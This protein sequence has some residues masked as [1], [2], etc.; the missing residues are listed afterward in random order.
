MKRD[1]GI[2]T[3]TYTLPEAALRL[4]VGKNTAYVEVRDTGKL[5]GIPVIKVGR[6]VT[7]SRELLERRLRGDVLP[8][9]RRDA[10]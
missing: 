4:G 10:A 7:V 6:R 9:D 5:A 2:I 8:G 1:K 3:G